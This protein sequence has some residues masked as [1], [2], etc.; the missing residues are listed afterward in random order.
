MNA[1]AVSVGVATN[2]DAVAVERRRCSV[3]VAMR[4]VML[5]DDSVIV[6]R[7]TKDSLV[8]G[9]VLVWCLGVCWFLEWCGAEWWMW[10][11]RRVD[12]YLKKLKKRSNEFGSDLDKSGLASSNWCEDELLSFIGEFTQSEE[13]AIFRAIY[14]PLIGKRPF[15]FV[16][17]KL[18]LFITHLLM[19]TKDRHEKKEYV[20]PNMFFMRQLGEAKKNKPLSTNTSSYKHQREKLVSFVEAEPIA[21]N[22]SIDES[23][24]KPIATNPSRPLK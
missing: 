16:I 17:A 12:F 1:G 22:P 19:A 7:H 2:V 21:T 23:V 11:C 6:L 24:N 4:A 9:S 18:S 15:K 20:K 8:C 5:I 3:V 14:E 13:W 10:W